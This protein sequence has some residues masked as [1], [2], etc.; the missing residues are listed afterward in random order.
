MHLDISLFCF[1]KQDKT[2]PTGKPLNLANPC[3]RL[4]PYN[5]INL[6]NDSVERKI[7]VRLRQ[8]QFHA[9][10]YSA[11]WAHRST[12]ATVALSIEIHNEVNQM[13]G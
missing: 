4:C 10:I 13:S 9:L 7:G 3:L 1:L 11:F 8:V 2:S 12:G 6:L 5:K